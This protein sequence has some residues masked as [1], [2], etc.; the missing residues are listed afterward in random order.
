MDT[1]AKLHW[2]TVAHTS[3]PHFDLPPTTEWSVW[4]DRNRRLTSWSNKVAI[5]LTHAKPTQTYWTKT[6]RIP[7]TNQPVAWDALYQVAY[8]STPLQR[9]VW[10]PKWLSAWLPIGKKLVRW[11][12]T[13][14]DVCP[15]CGESERHRHHVIQCPQDEAKHTW[16]AS[17]NKLDRWLTNKNYTQHDLHEG[18]L[19]GLSAWHDDRPTQPTTSDWPAVKQTLHDRQTLGWHLFFDG[20]ITHSWMATQQLYL[21]FLSKKMTGKR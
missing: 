16:Q 21:E 12:I 4:H 1:L 7:Q 10:I 17:L 13:Q 18:I 19:E 8:K 9:K 11:K 5:Q 6:Q 15:R 3:R 14:T 2:Q 20:F